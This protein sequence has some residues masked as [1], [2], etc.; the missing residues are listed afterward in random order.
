MEKRGVKKKK[1]KRKIGPVIEK[2]EKKMVHIDT[3]TT[4]L[5][6]RLDTP[7]RAPARTIGQKAADWLTKWA[8]SWVFIILLAIFMAIWIT[9]NT[10]WLL[11]GR[12]WD[13]YPFI[14]L[15]F[16]L[17]T[18]AAIQAPIILM[19]Q[20]RTSQRDRARSEYDYAVNKK[21]EKE[22]RQIQKQL[23]RIER[24]FIKEK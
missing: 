5:P 2:L 9:I 24:R 14:L 20:N 12:E 16:V 3:G 1:G 22:I 4:R 11:F 6:P 18:L 15:N 17:S 13:P 21:A 10:S 8:G 19:S 7:F 23:G